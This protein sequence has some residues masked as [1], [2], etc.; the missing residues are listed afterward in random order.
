[1]SRRFSDF[2]TSM[3]ETIPIPLPRMNVSIPSDLKARLD[4][5]AAAEGKTIQSLTA[6]IIAF[7]L[8]NMDIAGRLKPR[9]EAK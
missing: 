7:G 2:V 8:A 9:K 6:Q 4:R 3:P 1:M 5:R